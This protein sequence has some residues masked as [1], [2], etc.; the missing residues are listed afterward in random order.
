[1]AT[2]NMHHKW[3]CI[4]ISPLQKNI[5]YQINIT[6]QQGILSKTAT[7][8]TMMYCVVYVL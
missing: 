4:Q 7:E 3:F 8:P 6:R 1:M 5:P 2:C